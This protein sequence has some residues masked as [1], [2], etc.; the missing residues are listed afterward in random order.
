MTTAEDRQMKTAVAVV[1]A[2]AAAC[3]ARGEIGLA[4]RF[5][6]VI[7]EGVETGR[8]YSLREAARVPLGVENRGD[9]PTEVVIEFGRPRAGNI[10]GGYEAIPDPSWLKAVPDRLRMAPHSLGFVDLLLTLP[11]DPKLLKRHF[12]VTVKARSNDAG[13]LGVAVENRVRFS[14]GPG[15]ESLKAEKK[16]KAMQ[17]LDFDVTPRD[18]YLT[19]VPV[20]RAWDARKEAKKSIRVANYAPDRLTIVL[21]PEA[22]D[23]SV[24]MPEGYAKIPD[25][26]WIRLKTSTI[27]VGT[28]EIVQAMIVVK[29]PDAPAN[30]GKRWAA[31]IRTGLATG[32]WLDA[33]VKLFLET[34]P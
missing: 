8:T 30:R 14:V 21:T 18:L 32:F 5:G 23:E 28:D 1:F 25:L 2:L 16:K 3:P 13:L 20:G 27:S 24:P 34:K 10:A 9:G 17:Q 22:W 19:E 31:L 7:L 12:Q 33:P 26:S 11:D 4:A 29:V 6:D 15:P